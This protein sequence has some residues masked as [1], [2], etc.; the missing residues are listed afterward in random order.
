MDPSHIDLEFHPVIC[1]N[2]HGN[3]ITGSERSHV[4][5]QEVTRYSITGLL[6]GYGRRL[7]SAKTE[8]LMVST[9]G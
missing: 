4:V 7:L 9:D 2:R 5:Q 6:I 8:S 3:R 1:D